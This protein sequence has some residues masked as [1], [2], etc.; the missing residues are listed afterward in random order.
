MAELFI[1]GIKL[2]VRVGVY[3]HEKTSP[4][5]I[6]VDCRLKVDEVHTEELS[7]VVDYEALVKEITSSIEPKTFNLIETLTDRIYEICISKASWVEV[8]VTKKLNKEVKVRY[9]RCSKD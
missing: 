9:S 5:P 6:T 4:Q 3:E 1:Q 8:S 7:S 2:N